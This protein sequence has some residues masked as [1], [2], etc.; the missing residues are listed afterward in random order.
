[1]TSE[2][3]IKRASRYTI[4]AGTWDKKEYEGYEIMFGAVRWFQHMSFEV[5]MS[6]RA[7]AYLAVV[8]IRFL[9]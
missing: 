1:M 9:T 7:S 3:P 2:V 5:G 6:A 4:R 8:T